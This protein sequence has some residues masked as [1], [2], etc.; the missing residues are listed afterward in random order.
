MSG[1]L[2]LLSGVFIFILAIGLF[3]IPHHRSHRN[4]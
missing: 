3:T 2:F 4:K 1:L